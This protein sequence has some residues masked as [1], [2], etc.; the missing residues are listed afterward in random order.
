MSGKLQGDLTTAPGCLAPQTDLND[1]WDIMDHLFQEN[2]QQASEWFKNV[3]KDSLEELNDLQTLSDVINQC[4]KDWDFIEKFPHVYQVILYWFILLT[5][6]L[7]V[8]TAD[9]IR[10]MSD[11]EK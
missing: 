3:L 1:G 5:C 10:T 9:W 7:Q 8:L 4:S 2:A 11:S 6:T